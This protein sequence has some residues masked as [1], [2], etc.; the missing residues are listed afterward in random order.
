MDK[1]PACSPAAYP[2]RDPSSPLSPGTRWGP[3]QGHTCSDTWGGPGA[4]G[5]HSWACWSP[6]LQGLPLQVPLPGLP[7]HTLA[8]LPGPLSF[9]PGLG[10]PGRFGARDCL[11]PGLESLASGQGA[12]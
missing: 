4:R 7:S 11:S 9:K 12:L 6:R 3:A 8:G 1:P 10:V 5:P 2:G